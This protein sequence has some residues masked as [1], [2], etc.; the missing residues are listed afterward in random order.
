VFVSLVAR[1][2]LASR[3][4]QLFVPEPG[5]DA[6]PAF[7]AFFKSD[8]DR[9]VARRL[10]GT[11]MKEL[12]EDATQTIALK[13]IDDNYRRIRAYTGAGSFPGFILHTVD[14]LTI[15]FIRQAV[16]ARRQSE[17][18]APKNKFVHIDDVDPEFDGPSPEQSLVDAQD[19][20]LSS[21]AIEVL[22]LASKE[23]SVPE[24][25]YVQVIL[26]HSAVLAARE[27]AKIMKRP[28]EE[29]YKLRQRVLLRLRELIERN[30][31]VKNWR[32]SV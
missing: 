2:I 11:H 8:I 28:V 10:P 13:L 18:G 15:D 32:A 20:E 4:V 16:S 25:L 19:V 3:L 17:A 9:V 6:W 1:D 22:K 30:P 23:L 21:R 5:P 24:Q 31:D 26:D 29:I 27:V 12:R 7:Q 14:R